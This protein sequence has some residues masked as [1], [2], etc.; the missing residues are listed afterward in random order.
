M[1]AGRRFLPLLVGRQLLA[2]MSEIGP[3]LPTKDRI[4]PEQVRG[5][6]ALINILAHFRDED[7]DAHNDGDSDP[8][9]Q[10]HPTVVLE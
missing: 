6:F 8:D 5:S 4:P 9:P 7:Y 10:P 1:L 2:L 3:R